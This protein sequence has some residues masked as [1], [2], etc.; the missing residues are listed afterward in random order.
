MAY[1]RSINQV[2]ILN[3]EYI[4]IINAYFKNII[5]CTCFI[6]SKDYFYSFGY[7]KNYDFVPLPLPSRYRPVTVTLPSRYSLQSPVKDRYRFF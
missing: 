4:T 1:A 7:S 3:Y 6:L 2:T 5:F